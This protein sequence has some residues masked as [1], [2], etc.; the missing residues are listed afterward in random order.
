MT[1]NTDTFP[2]PLGHFS[3]ALTPAG[4]L[5][6]T[7]FGD[8]SALSKRLPRGAGCNVLCYKS[9]CAEAVRAQVEEYFAGRRRE[10]DLPI[11]ASGTAFQHKVWRALQ[12]IPYGRTLSYGALATRLRMRQA[13]RAVGRANA[14]NPLCL[15]VPC[16]RMIGADGSLTGFAFGEEI[17]QRLLEHEGSLAPRAV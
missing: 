17:K 15:I 13:A 8:Q 10:F 2:T 1:L 16:H 7:A 12:A 4:A 3:V 5:V 6:T 9:G 11:A 14:T